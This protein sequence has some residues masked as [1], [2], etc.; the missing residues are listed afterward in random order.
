MR[1]LWV[2]IFEHPDM[3]L[4]WTEKMYEVQEYVGTTHE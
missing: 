1:T 2:W 3:R 4:G